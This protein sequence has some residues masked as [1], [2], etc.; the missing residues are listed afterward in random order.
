MARPRIESPTPRALFMVFSE[1]LFANLEVRRAETKV[2]TMQNT[3]EYGSV[4]PP[5]MAKC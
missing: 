2:K 4:I 1:A 5:L 3:R